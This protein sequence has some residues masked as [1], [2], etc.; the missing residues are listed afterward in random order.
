MGSWVSAFPRWNPLD[1]QLCSRE[2]RCGVCGDDGQ[3]GGA[4]RRAL[5][6]PQPLRGI[7]DSGFGVGCAQ[8][9]SGVREQLGELLPET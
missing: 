1:V 5:V 4:V 8:S 9:V 7:W 2:Y 3:H 6:C